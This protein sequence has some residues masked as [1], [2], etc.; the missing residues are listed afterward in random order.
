[1]DIHIDYGCLTIIYQHNNICGLEI[2]NEQG[3]W[4]KVIPKKS[5][6]IINF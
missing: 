6:F 4:K 5:K 3:E 2:E 1:M